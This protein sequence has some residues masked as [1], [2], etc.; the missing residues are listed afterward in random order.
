MA[1]ET[2]YAR[3]GDVFIAYQVTGQ[4]G[5]EWGSVNWTVDPA[6]EQPAAKTRTLHLLAT[7]YECAG[8]TPLR[9]RLAPAWVFLEPGRVRV[10]LF[11]QLVMAGAKCEHLKP[12][13]VTVRL[14]EP[15]GT[16]ELVDANPKPCPGCGG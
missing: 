14:P 6:Y 11:A 5:P 15:L 13:K 12:T 3:S 16:R 9:G 4:P 7:E 8:D 10:Q 2:H 1:A